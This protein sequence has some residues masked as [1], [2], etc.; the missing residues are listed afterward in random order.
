MKPWKK[1]N[2]LAPRYS[3]DVSPFVE[4]QI[5]LYQESKKWFCDVYVED[6][7]GVFRKEL[8]PGVKSAR[9]AKIAAM[10]AWGEFQR[11]VGE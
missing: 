2:T 11:E 5:V 10:H 7:S 8:G 6:F 3:R 4:I 1:I 9:H